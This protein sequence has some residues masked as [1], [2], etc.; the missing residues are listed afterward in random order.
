MKRKVLVLLMVLSLTLSLM[1]VMAFGDDETEGSVLSYDTAETEE[2]ESEEP[3]Q[4]STEKEEAEEENHNDTV[5][6]AL[7]DKGAAE[8]PSTQ[9]IKDEA[10][11]AQT[12]CSHANTYMVEDYYDVTCTEIKGD[13]RYHKMTGTIAIIT[14]CEDCGEEVKRVTQ[15]VKG[16]EYE[17]D[18]EEGECIDCG[19]KNTCKHKNTY[20]DEEWD[21]EE[22]TCT[23]IKGDNRYHKMTG[24]GEKVTYCDDCG[25]ELNREEIKIKGKKYEHEYND[26]HICT[27]C[28][29]KNSC[30]H[31]HTDYDYFW[32]RDVDNVKF[33]KKDNTYHR[34]TGTGYLGTWCDDCGEIFKYKK[35]KIDDKF[36]HNYNSK[37][38]CTDC[39]QTNTCKHPSEVSEYYYDDEVCK[40]VDTG[41]GSKHKV[42]GN[43]TKITYCKVCK[44]E[45]KKENLGK[46]TVT[47]PHEYNRDDVCIYCGYQ[48]P[49]LRAY[50]DGR[51]DT[52]IEV[53]EEYKGSAGKFENVIVAYGRN[54][55]DALS[56]G[57]LA[58]TKN[59]PILLVE[60]S[61]EDRIVEYISNNILIG[62]KVYILGG[63]GAV[64]AAFE[65]KVKAKGI[66][67]TRLGGKDRYETNLK[68]LTEAGV[69]SE[70]ILVCTGAGFADSLSAAAVG[71]PILLVGNSL[72][73]GQKKYI[74][75]LSSK[76]IY[77]IGGKGAVKPAVETGLKDLGF[78]KVERI[79]GKTR[80][81]TSTEVAK[82][83]FSKAKTVVLAYAQNFPDGL[84]G[85]P[86]AMMKNAPIILT[87][88]GN[89]AAA[90]AYV[91]SA[92]AGRNVTLGGP[93]L[94]SDIAVRAIMSR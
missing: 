40:I 89:T 22:V 15:K 48:K 27:V 11:N 76:K 26:K 67:T 93:A 54:F 34:V 58:K 92:G 6:E 80:Y 64:S 73:D 31:V 83:F 88:S 46:T 10:L 18:Y 81:E 2:T 12:K 13:N 51:Y 82:K 57:Y 38:V 42:T 41:D 4:D 91:K 25:E 87:D 20:M 5:N 55:P 66:A 86:L 53:A 21:D 29:H 72:T 78:S 7:T 94:I 33:A 8:E 14:Y 75:G 84:S 56:G 17:H 77:L 3:E 61:V 85:G 37:H 39:G 30:K 90:R 52:A 47:E 71:K 79:A 36:I 24:I 44:E 9:M 43:I 63:T 70:D 74:N 16:E 60:P 69:K 23:E 19:H 32:D 65:S 49:D 68:I 1:P 50:G 45:R 28:N 59:A 35:I 62:G